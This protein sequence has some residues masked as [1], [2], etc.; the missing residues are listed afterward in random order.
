MATKYVYTFSSVGHLPLQTLHSVQ[1]LRRYVD[2]TNIVIF[3]T[4]PI[5]E[6]DV[7]MFQEFNVDIRIVD[8]ITEPFAAFNELPR[9][10]GEK[11]H[12]CGVDSESV[13]FLD[14]DTL[15][16]GDIERC[17]EG[18]FDFKARPGTAKGNKDEWERLFTTYNK[19]VLNWM[20]NAGFLVFKNGIH[21]EIKREWLRFLN[22]DL[23]YT[24]GNVNHKEQYALA[25]AVAEYKTAKLNAQEHV[26]EWNGER[27]SDGIVYHIGR[28][29]DESPDG[30]KQSMSHL[31]HECKQK[32]LSIVP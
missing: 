11:V 12:L 28:T 29:F 27:P 31:Y 22:E 14:C 17:L 32:F 19:P 24:K 7:K 5:N 16:F 3:A 2:E 8:P 18:D 6:D 10:Y 9:H 23:H 15:I 30:V 25:L 1:T 21:K 13:V 4:P 20:P 26:M